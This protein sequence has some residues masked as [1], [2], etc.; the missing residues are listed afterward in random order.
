MQT[1]NLRI[2]R[3]VA[4]A[5]LLQA[6]GSPKSSSTSG[7]EGAA[8][9]TSRMTINLSVTASDANTAVVRANL[10][11]G[12]VLSNSYRLDGGD[13]FRTCVNG[14]CRNMADNDSI[15]TPDYIARFDYQPGVEYVVSF[16]R[17]QDRNAPDSRVILPPAFTIVT[18]ANRQQVTDGETVVVSWSPTGAPARV[19]MTYA[20]ECTLVGGALSVSSGTLSDDENADGSESVRIDPIVNFVRSSSAGSISRCSI[21]V[22]V[23]HELQGRI[24][25]AFRNGTAMGIVS[26]KVT[27][28]Y[29]PR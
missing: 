16:Y 5:A 24:D 8:V 7:P 15:Y 12:K 3:C 18:P 2:L 22:I 6:C 9:P 27:L 1:N 21:D 20:A 19:A 28:D 13:Y 17:N 4:L 11:D 29:I 10:N 26:R 23:R 14:V 25:P